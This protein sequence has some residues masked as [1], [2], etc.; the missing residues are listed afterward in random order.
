MCVSDG[1]PRHPK[2]QD[3]KQ[4]GMQELWNFLA[5]HNAVYFGDPELQKE[6]EAFLKKN[7]IKRIKATDKQREYTDLIKRAISLY[8]AV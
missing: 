7:K 1:A 4:K 8:P 2:S 5:G 6:L 3:E